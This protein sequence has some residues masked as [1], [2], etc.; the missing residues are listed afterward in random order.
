MSWVRPKKWQKNKQTN[1]KIEWS[2]LVVQQ[3]K[4]MVLSVQSGVGCYYGK[5]SILDPGTSYATSMSSCKKQTNKQKKQTNPQQLNAFK[6]G[7]NIYGMWNEALVSF[8]CSMNIRNIIFSL[9]MNFITFLVVHH[10]QTQIF[11]FCFWGPHSSH[12][13][14]PRLGVKSEL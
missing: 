8:G 12:M 4:D 2:S 5:G 1:K 3:I 13:E 9:T 7:I 11:F 14:V 10:H 6:Q